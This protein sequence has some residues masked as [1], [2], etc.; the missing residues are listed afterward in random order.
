M[1]LAAGSMEEPR[2]IA[3]MQQTPLPPA[4]AALVPAG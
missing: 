2:P 4:K 3:D 1:W